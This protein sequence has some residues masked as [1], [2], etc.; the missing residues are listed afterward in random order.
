MELSPVFARR[1]YLAL[2]VESLD[3]PNVPKL[4]E[5]RGGLVVL[6]KMYS[7]RYRGSVS[8]LCLFKMGDV[9]MM[10]I[11]S[12]PTGGHLTVNGLSSVKAI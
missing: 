12:Y 8:N 2:L 4:I 5:K 7:R 9:I 3:R 11:T 1:L 6:F 10:A